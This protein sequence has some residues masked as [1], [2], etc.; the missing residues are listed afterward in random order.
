MTAYHDSEWGVPMTDS[1]LLYK[2]IVLQSFQ[3]GLSWST[4]FKKVKGFEARFEGW[5][6][7]KVSKWTQG[8]IDEAVLDGNIV[9]NRSKIQAAV[10]NAKI[11]V[12]LDELEKN[13]FMKFVWTHCGS[14]PEVERLLQHST[15]NGS[16]M[17]SN[18]KEDHVLA[19]GVHP[20]IG[21]SQAAA[22]F[23]KVLYIYVCLYI[24][25]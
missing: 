12:E 5:D 20:T 16:H 11:A 10:N 7:N 23:K 21:V 13:G 4:I 18:S 24:Y 19:D 15:T 8:E 22:I 25:I 2:Q 14:L 6:Y 3:S 9:K 1:K 17:R